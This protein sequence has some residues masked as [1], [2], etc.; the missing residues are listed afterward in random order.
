MTLHKKYERCT[1]YRAASTPRRLPPYAHELISARQ[2]NQF[3][4]WWGSSA[5]GERPTLIVCTGEHAWRTAREWAGHRLVTLLPP[6]DA[7][8]IYDWRCLAGVDPV[9]LWRCGSV[10][11]ETL[12]KLI[13][14]VM[15]DGTERIL[16]LVTGV[17]YR[18]RRGGGSRH[19]A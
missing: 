12:E 5:D 3:R 15:R 7:P 18:A 17:R 10:D 16:D 6:G 2:C 19:A 13:K 11:G 9:L 4:G 14:A 8:E 1:S